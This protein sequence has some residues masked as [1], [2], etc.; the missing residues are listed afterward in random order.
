MLDYHEHGCGSIG[1]WIGLVCAAVGV[2]TAALMVYALNLDWYLFPSN[3]PKEV[4]VG[5]VALF[6][7]AVYLGKK[8]GVY[9]CGKHSR[10]S[11][12]VLVG[13]GV[14]FGSI[15]IAVLAGTLVAIVSN[16]G[17]IFSDPDF[18]PFNLV[19]GFFLMLGL[20]LLFGGVPA[21]VLGVLYGFL[22]RNRLRELI[23]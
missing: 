17:E 1:T 6:L 10:L 13:L 16:P 4:V 14:A 12:N 22:V 8:S 7:A 5:V 21:V 18:N 11:L 15:S 23:R 19:L 9:L 20:V 2:G 3:P